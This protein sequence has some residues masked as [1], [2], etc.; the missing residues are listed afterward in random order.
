MALHSEVDKEG[1]RLGVHASCEHDVLEDHLLAELVAVEDE[2]VVD[3]LADQ[4]DWL[5]GSVSIDGWHVDVID[6]ED[7]LLVSWGSVSSSKLLD[8]D[9]LDDTLEGAGISVRVEVDRR[10]EG[11][12][13]IQLGEVILDD[14]GLTSSGN[15]REEHAS[16]GCLVDVDQSGLAS[17]LSGWHDQVVVKTFPLRVHGLHAV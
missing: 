11:F 16:L 4:S 15:T 13:S 12:L 10:A 2:A 6:E 14:C 1:S 5:L 7:E 8:N 3:N 17:S 9:G